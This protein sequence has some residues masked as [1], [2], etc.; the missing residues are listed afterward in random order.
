MKPRFAVATSAL[1]L[2]AAL[3]VPLLA[4]APLDVIGLTDASYGNYA[5]RVTF[6]VPSTN[7]YSYRVLLD[8]NPVPT[9]VPMTVTNIDYHELSVWRTNLQTSAVSNRL[10]RFIVLNSS[11]RTGGSTEDGIPSWT[12]YPSINSATAEFAGAH[13]RLIAPQAFPTGYPIPIVAWV[14]N[15]QGHSVRVTGNL[16]AAGHPSIRIKRGVGSGFLDATNGAGALAYAP[17]IGGLAASPSISLEAGTS[18]TTVPGGTLPANTAWPANSRIYIASSITNAA[19]STLTIGA[20]TI[21][22]VNPNTDIANNGAIV[23]S[24]TTT[25]PVVFMPATTGQPWGGF[26]QHANN[27]SFTATGAIFTGCGAVPCWYTGHGCSGST[28]GIGSHRGE[29]ALI[30]LRGINC[31]LTMTDCAAI[32]MAGQLSHS[33]G[34]S[35]NTYA[36]TLTRFLLQRSTTGGEFT[37]ARFNVNDSAFIELNEDLGTGEGPVFIDADN[38]G[39]YI[40]DAINGA[41]GFTNTMWGWTWDDGVDSGGDGAGQLNFQNCWFDSIYH[42]ANSLSGTGK[43]SRHSGDV[44]INCGQALEDGYSGPTGRLDRCL[45]VNNLI[46]VRF[47]DN[48]A[49]PSY[50]Y[51]GS[52]RATNSLVLN[53]YRDAWGFNWQDWTYRARSMD[54]RSNFLTAANT[55]HPSNAIWNPA[56]DFW[57][58]TNYMTIPYDAAVG[59]GFGVWTTQFALSNIFDG[60]PVRLSHF[61][62]NYVSVDYAFANNI[63]PLAAGTLTFAPGETLKRIYPSGFNVSAQS[64]VT[65]G[66][67]N[68]VQCELTGETNLTF[69]GS[70]PPTQVRCYAGGSQED[71]ARLS[72]GIAVAL[73]GPSAQSVTVDYKIENGG[74][75][76]ASGTLVFNPGETLRWLS[77]PGV[78]A[79]NFNLLR[80]SLSNPSS[81][82][83]ATPSNYFLVRTPFPPITPPPTTLL[84]A[85]SAW[86]YLDTGAN[87]GAPWSPGNLSGWTGTNFNDSTWAVGTAPLGY[88]NSP[89]ETTTVGGGPTGSR[90]I[91]TYFRTAFMVTNAASLANLTFSLRRDDGAV[92]YLNGPEV[93]RDNMPGTAIIYTTPSST[94]N[95]GTVTAFNSVTVPV[96]SLS[97]PLHD[98]FNEVAVEIHQNSGTSSDIVFDLQIVGTQ[99]APPGSRPSLYWGQFD[100]TNVVLGWSDP[101]YRLLQ[102]NSITGLWTNAAS[103]SPFTLQPAAPERYYELRSP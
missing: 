33:V 6:R 84:T 30:A 50:S 90:F 26:V 78:T 65:L 89:L 73:N 20:G 80:L 2:Y 88:G 97:P 35:G 70:V 10:V 19:G 63:G 24:G 13:L 17:T 74:Q 38:D 56:V 48:Y 12:P 46:G 98:G 44:M 100:S 5:D 60:L 86:R 42:E 91:T 15:D 3:A 22:K 95:S 40:V 99:A 39:L 1:F 101:A 29:Q 31:N 41:H 36:I 94:N 18:W 16:G 87:L 81:A 23:I 57:R 59:A 27:A 103:I 93:Y 69:Q 32:F 67:R 51:S 7:G 37:G 68:P 8:A 45:V 34:G 72:E 58:L 79:S 28:S 66:L 9:D 76:L 62:T 55:F 49:P 92:V 85:G 53:N 61:T 52:I 4:Q 11:R 75:L 64:L 14:E 21:V 25:Q 83:L 82:T 77:V 47:G 43:D 102:A 54:V 96:A 71:V